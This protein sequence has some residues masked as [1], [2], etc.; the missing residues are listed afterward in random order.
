MSILVGASEEATGPDLPAF[1]AELPS[2]TRQYSYAWADND[3]PPPVYPGTN[4]SV[5]KVERQWQDETRRDANRDSA[6]HSDADSL[7]L[8]SLW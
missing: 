8:H 3:K 2:E 5:P 4:P 1:R 7:E 6:V